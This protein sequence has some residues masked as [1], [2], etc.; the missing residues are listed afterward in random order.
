[1]TKSYRLWLSTF[2]T[3]AMVFFAMT[4]VVLV[5]KCLRNNSTAFKGEVTSIT[6][7]SC[8]FKKINLGKVKSDTILSFSYHL[9]NVGQNSLHIISVTPDCN[10]TGYSLSK[11]V[12]DVGDSINLKLNV[13]MKNKHKGKF[14]LN[15][16][17]E[18]NTRQ[19]LYHILIEGERI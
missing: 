6:E 5:S 14:M 9:I 7:A 13:D 1:M 16:V 19:R 15:T 8:N 3:I 17:V 4:I 18:L 2:T 12:A 11:S 10:C